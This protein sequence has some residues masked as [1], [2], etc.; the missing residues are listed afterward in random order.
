MILLKMGSVYMI[1]GVVLGGLLV[2]LV[3]FV[4]LSRV[5]K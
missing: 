5:K 1:F 3:V 4:W 2:I